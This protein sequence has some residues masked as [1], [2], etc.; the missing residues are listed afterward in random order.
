M[1]LCVCNNLNNGRCIV[2]VHKWSASAHRRLAAVLLAR[3]RFYDVHG[4]S[5]IAAIK[6]GNIARFGHF[7][8]VYSCSATELQLRSENIFFRPVAGFHLAV[9]DLWHRN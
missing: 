8:Y 4:S 9:S 6:L 2:V 5:L 3:G 7:M 1:Q